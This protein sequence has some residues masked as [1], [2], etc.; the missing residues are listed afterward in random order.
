RYTRIENPTEDASNTNGS[1]TNRRSDRGV[2]ERCLTRKRPHCNLQH[3]C[4]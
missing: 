3:H 1:D 4:K 2:E